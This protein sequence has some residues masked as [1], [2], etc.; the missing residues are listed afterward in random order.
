MTTMPDW[1]SSL[2]SDWMFYGPSLVSDEV[3]VAKLAQRTTELSITATNKSI[4]STTSMNRRSSLGSMR[5]T[6]TA[7]VQTSTASDPAAAP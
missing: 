6:S 1:L 4:A 2:E 5:R 7:T 3:L